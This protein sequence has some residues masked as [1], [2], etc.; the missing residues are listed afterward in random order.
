M[1]VPAFKLQNGVFGHLHKEYENERE[2]NRNKLSDKL[3][4]ARP[5]SPA[6]PE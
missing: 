5:V 1:A 3:P 2:A 4:R 6:C